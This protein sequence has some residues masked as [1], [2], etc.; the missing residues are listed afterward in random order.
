MALQVDFKIEFGRMFDAVLKFAEE[1][2]S[3]IAEHPE[4]LKLQKSGKYSKKSIESETDRF[5]N[6]AKL[7]E[8]IET[9]GSSNKIN[10][11]IQQVFDSHLETTNDI[12][13]YNYYPR[14]KNKML[15]VDNESKNI[16]Q[17]HEIR[18]RLQK[19]KKARRSSNHYNTGKTQRSSSSSRRRHSLPEKLE[20]PGIKLLIKNAQCKVVLPTEILPEE[21]STVVNNEIRQKRKGNDNLCS[22]S[23]KEIKSKER[24]NMFQYNLEDFE[25]FERLQLT[26]VLDRCLFAKE[27]V[28]GPNLIESQII[29]ANDN[30]QLL[31][32]KINIESPVP[33]CSLPTPSPTDSEESLIEAKVDNPTSHYDIPKMEKGYTTK[34]T[35]NISKLNFISPTSINVSQRNDKRSRY[36]VPDTAEGLLKKPRQIENASSDTR[37]Q[38]LQVDE[39]VPEKMAELPKI[40]KVPSIGIGFSQ[41]H[42]YLQNL[43]NVGAS[44]ESRERQHSGNISG[45]IFSFEGSG[46]RIWPNKR[47]VFPELNNG[48]PKNASSM[49]TLNI[50]TMA[51]ENPQQKFLGNNSTNRDKISFGSNHKSI[52]LPIRRLN[53]PMPKYLLVLVQH[54]N[55]TE[56]LFAS[57]QSEIHK[58]EFDCMNVVM[59]EMLAARSELMKG[60]V[61][62]KTDTVKIMN[63]HIKYLTRKREELQKKNDP[64]YRNI[65]KGTSGALNRLLDVKKYM[66]DQSDMISLPGTT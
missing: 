12:K 65:Y 42:E 10:T 54:K 43:S 49:A 53:I 29:G 20:S 46:P 25:N 35:Q 50:G 28:T 11:G 45:N 41:E 48:S 37:S 26:E 36:N 1:S 4:Q 62:E 19:Q 38:D 55:K 64:K 5:E 15:D 24:I 60:K 63:F 66:E 2:L 21:L 59:K 33:S 61:S 52:I 32:N 40:F 18:E 44:S 31:S 58:L 8:C 47:K 17:N 14:Q 6:S 3:K 51:E 9:E 22:T 13:E 34:K 57:T 39:Q 16:K 30:S 23:P 56:D 27:K 7:S